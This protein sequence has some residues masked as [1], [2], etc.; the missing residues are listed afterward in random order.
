M[1]T[2]WQPGQ[3]GNP[4][5]RPAGLTLAGRLR[6]AVGREFDAIVQAV[7]ESAK[8]GDMAA[9]N[10][11][12]SRT[13]PAVRPVQEPMQVAMPGASL[14]E[15]AGAILDAVGRGELAP[16]DAKALLDGLAA[17]ARIVEIDD[18]AARVAALEGKQP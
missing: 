1:G 16:Q 8:A 9:A 15:K 11:L 14:S 18:L 12:L 2:K 3:S 6:E 5:G 4:S 10:L 13:C 7:I 17:V